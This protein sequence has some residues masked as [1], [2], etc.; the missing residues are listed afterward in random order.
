MTDDEALTCASRSAASAAPARGAASPP[1]CP[2]RHPP[3][4]VA[5]CLSRAGRRILTCMGTKSRETIY[6]ASAERATEAV[7]SSP[8]GFFSVPALAMRLARMIIAAVG[9]LLKQ[10]NPDYNFARC[11]KTSE[12]LKSTRADQ[13]ETVGASCRS[14]V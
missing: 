1:L 8:A 12:S 3:Q 13:S 7:C 14:T 10:V 5:A 11:C 2:V 4:S 9:D 6:G